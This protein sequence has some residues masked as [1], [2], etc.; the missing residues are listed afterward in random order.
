MVRFPEPIGRYIGEDVEHAP[1]IGAVIMTPAFAFVF[2]S[3]TFG[4]SDRVWNLTGHS[5]S[6]V[7]V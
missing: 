4:A 3:H 1:Y 6:R 7:D 5:N 2:R